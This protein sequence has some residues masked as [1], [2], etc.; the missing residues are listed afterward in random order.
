MCSFNTCAVQFALLTIVVLNF[1]MF[2]FI[3]VVIG[4]SKSLLLPFLADFKVLIRSNI[5]IV[6]LY[7]YGKEVEHT[8]YLLRQF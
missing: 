1:C 3:A 7:Y 4:C 2:E 8:K 6:T 5:F